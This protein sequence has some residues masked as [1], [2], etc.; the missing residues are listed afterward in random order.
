MI[1]DIVDDHLQLLYDIVG[2]YS[3]RQCVVV[4]NGNS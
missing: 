2:F 1:C 3:T 4:V